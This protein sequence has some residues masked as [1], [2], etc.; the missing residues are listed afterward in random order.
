LGIL[1]K[2]GNIPYVL[3]NPLQYSNIS[4]EIVDAREKKK[5]LGGSINVAAVAQTRL[6]TSAYRD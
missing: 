5:R 2:I 3:E 6:D 1:G 4:V